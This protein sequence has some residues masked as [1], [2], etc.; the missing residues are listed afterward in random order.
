M[1]QLINELRALPHVDRIAQP[2][3]E[4]Q[5]LLTL[6]S[7]F[8]RERVRVVA[9]RLGFSCR[10]VDINDGS[11]ELDFQPLDDLGNAPSGVVISLRNAHNPRRLT[12][13]PSFEILGPKRGI[14]PEW[15]AK[16]I[17]F[18]KALKPVGHLSLVKK[19][20]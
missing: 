18:F 11:Y 13:V 9:R 16:V 5:I 3:R 2:T 15:R 12:R 19:E 8:T 7:S 4:G 17:E 14:T 10:Q 6:E 1:N 20:T